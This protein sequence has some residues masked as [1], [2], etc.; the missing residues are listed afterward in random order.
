[1]LPQTGF[2]EKLDPGAAVCIK[3]NL[4]VAKPSSSGATTDPELVSAIIEL[5][6]ERGI[7]D[8]T[9]AESAWVQESTARAFKVCGY[10][11]ISHR[12]GIPLVDL[13]K[14]RTVSVQAGN[15]EIS[16]AETVLKTD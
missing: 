8:I 5:L 16:V 13:K 15:Y 2:L 6:L 4:V 1:M 7:K 3:P 11:D 12:Y 10:E 9:I 14:D